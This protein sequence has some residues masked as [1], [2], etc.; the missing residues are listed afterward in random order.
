MP[1]KKKQET[2][3]KLPTPNSKVVKYFMAKQEG[4]NQSEA[5]TIAGYSLPETHSTRV[6]QSK[7][8]QAL[9]RHYKD[10]LQDQISLKEIAQNHAEIIRQNN[11]MGPKVVAI[12]MAYEKIEPEENID[13]S[14]EAVTVI[15][16]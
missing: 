3:V 9:A 1:K 13:D 5:A 4:K 10:E 6:E 14:G 7:G 11:E 8:Y 2:L 16:K 15:L 12:R